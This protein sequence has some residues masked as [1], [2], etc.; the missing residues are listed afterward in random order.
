M[1]R[2]SLLHEAADRAAE[3][4]PE[5][6]AFRY[7][8]TAISFADLADRSSRLARVLQDHGVAPGDRVGVFLNKSLEMPVAVY[9][10]LHAGAAFVPIDPA[11]GPER[12][13]TMLSH[14][15]IRHVV[16]QPN[17]RAIIEEVI[18]PDCPLICAL[19]LGAE[20]PGVQTPTW[21]DVDTAPAVQPV[22]RVTQDMAYIISTSGSTG[23]PKGIVHTHASGLAYTRM[24]LELYGVS[25]SDRLANH[26]ALHFDMATFEF[27]G[28]PNAEATVILIPEMYTKVPASLSELIERERV[29]IWYSVPFAL[30]QLLQ[31]GALD[32]RDLSAIRWVNFGGEPYPAKHLSAL[33]KLWPHARF[34]NVFGPAETNQC[35]FYH[36]DTPI[37]P[38]AETVPVGQMCPNADG[39]ILDEHDKP[40]TK[41]ETGELVVRSPQLMRGYWADPARN[42]QCF[43]RR[44]LCDGIDDVYYRTGDLVQEA[45]D[46]MIFLGRKDRQI[47]VRGYRVELDEVEAVLTTHTDVEMAAA[48]PAAD[49][50]T[51]GAAV[52]LQGAR[53]DGPDLLGH[54]Q[55]LLPAYA[56]PSSI[57]VLE[58]LPLTGTQKIDRKALAAMD[59][60]PDEG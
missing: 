41:G 52:T 25:A 32:Q 16:T 12:L 31:H 42:A 26:S 7:L 43:Y 15:G 37:A 51:I 28:G 33:M 17:K 1:T 56:V 49:G 4:A 6:D 40:V 48:Y 27:F 54:C 35:S 39:L 47:K 20:I 8:D 2:I 59:A 36:L 46:A 9:A 10:I 50:E 3:R 23:V 29:T 30:I 24:A 53:A 5:R 55:R 45:G 22:R 44:P 57:R 38:D 34:S 19:G 58:S 11:I 18:G 13:K 14:C 21:E 60:A